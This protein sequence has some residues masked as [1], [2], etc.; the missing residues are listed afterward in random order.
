MS[1]NNLYYLMHKNDI[2]AGIEIDE[3]SGHI[4]KVALGMYDKELLP[5]GGRL[6]PD[7]LKIW[8]K[9]RAVPIGQGSMRRILE[10]NQ[11]NSPQI[12]LVKN[13]GVSLTDHY[14]IKPV[15][16]DYTWEKV[17]LF[18]NTF[19]DDMAEMY[20]MGMEEP[21]AFPVMTTFYPSASAQGELQKKWI[22][23]NGKRYLVKGNYGAACQQSLNEV[24][25][26]KIHEKQ[27]AMPYAVYSICEVKTLTGKSI[28]CIC[29]NFA[30]EDVEFIP[31]YDVVNSEKKRNDMSEYE[32]FIQI[33]SKNGLDAEEVRAFL[34]YQIMTDFL[35]TNTDR[36]F[37]NFGILRDSK[38]LKY[39]RMAPIFD[40]GNSMFWNFSSIPN[41]KE[42]LNISVNSFRKRETD[43]LRY[44]RNK[45][46]VEIGNLPNERELIN[47]YQQS[48]FLEK[49]IPGILSGYHKKIELLEKFQKGEHIWQFKSGTE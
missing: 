34:E 45:K 18:T 8:W 41:D 36:H 38:T 33:C 40:S 29:E 30:S 31:A 19:R 42:I 32:H 22:I 5:P 44:I 28:G 16:S 24:A 13:C 46:L 23:I 25:A 10:A 49:R 39:I 6:S 37:N 21:E 1:F 27:N 48:P 35:I 15:E 3:V 12:Y 2:A 7:A 17:N 20:V 47:I 43:L 14:W 4:I 9:N 11:I 26:V